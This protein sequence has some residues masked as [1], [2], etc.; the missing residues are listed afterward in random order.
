[1]PNNLLT[2]PVSKDLFISQDCRENLLRSLADSFILH[3]DTVLHD[4]HAS[5]HALAAPLELVRSLS[6]RPEGVASLEAVSSSL[7]PYLFLYAFLLPQF[8]SVEPVQQ[9]VAAAL[10]KTGIDAASA[11]V[12]TGAIAVIKQLL[13]ELLVDCTA[14]PTYVSPSCT[15]MVPA[16]IRL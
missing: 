7:L 9:G 4:E 11:E 15:C 8:A 5:L 12:K 3:F 16:K 10:W 6:E 14:R 1:M 2:S 13:R